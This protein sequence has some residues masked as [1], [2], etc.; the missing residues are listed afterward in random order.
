M[1]LNDLRQVFIGNGNLGSFYDGAE[2]KDNKLDIFNFF[3]LKY[4]QKGGL[5]KV[6]NILLVIKK[7]IVY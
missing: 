4:S 6:F 5:Q 3:G 7:Y 1:N 2:E